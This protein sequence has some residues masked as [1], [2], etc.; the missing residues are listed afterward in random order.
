MYT[1]N[2]DP[3]LSRDRDIKKK[4][5]TLFNHVV[6]NEREGELVFDLSYFKENRKFVYGPY[7]KG[8]QGDHTV[9]YSILISSLE[10]RLSNKTPSELM[11]FIL[12]DRHQPTAPSLNQDILILFH[13]YSKVSGHY[14]DYFV[15]DRIQRLHNSYKTLHSG[16]YLLSDDELGLVQGKEKEFYKLITNYILDYVFVLQTLPFSTAYAEPGFGSGYRGEGSSKEFIKQL[17]G[18]SPSLE[19]ECTK[20]FSKLLD[21]KAICNVI[22]QFSQHPFSNFT[23]QW[24]M[25]I[26]AYQLVLFLNILDGYPKAKGYFFQQNSNA[27]TLRVSRAKLDNI[28]FILF[29]EGDNEKYFE[30]IESALYQIVRL[31]R[32]QFNYNWLS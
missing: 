11:R 3:Q 28:A 8:N 32:C 13:L 2:I 30:T 17:T 24:L 9:C 14:Q 5:R 12:S 7:A 1:K 26:V 31:R 23:K 27:E 15:R 25:D 22:Q 4:Q 18:F 29:G 10:Q 21:Q 16:V 20:K 6:I 19:E